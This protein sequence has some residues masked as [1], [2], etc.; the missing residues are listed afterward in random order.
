MTKL[1]YLF[2]TE[3]TK[4]KSV[5]ETNRYPMFVRKTKTVLHHSNFIKNVTNR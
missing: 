5:M 1:M 4:L 3:E 2:E